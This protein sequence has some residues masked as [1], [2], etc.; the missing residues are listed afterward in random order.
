MNCSESEQVL[1]ELLDGARPGPQPALDHHLAECQ[2][3]RELHRAARRLEAGLRRGSLPPAS[4]PDALAD[5][6]VARILAVRRRRVLGRRLLLAAAAA[7]LLTLLPLC[8]RL[9][10]FG[11]EQ[12]SARPA[13]QVARAR[14]EKE[15]APAPSLQSKVEE[16]RTA[17]ASWT[18]RLAAETRSKA[19]T[20]LQAAPAMSVPLEPPP[21]VADESAALDPAVHS[22]QEAGA[23]VTANFQT[24]A[25]SARRA[26]TFFAQE[27][28]ALK[29]TQ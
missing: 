21:G 1:H 3:C 7:V 10:H 17:L 5:R 2:R 16:A 20:L 11:D 4:P 27:I 12:N 18:D 24:V 13:D 22:L 6:T 29:S 8:Q 14:V 19:E 9:L 28:P 25:G 23:Q 15:R 26:V